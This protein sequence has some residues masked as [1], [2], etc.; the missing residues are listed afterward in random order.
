M[1]SKAA[2]ATKEGQKWLTGSAKGQ[3]QAKP[4]W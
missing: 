1:T 3:V 2:G 4:A